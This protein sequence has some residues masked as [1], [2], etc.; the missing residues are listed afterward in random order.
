[1]TYGL[2]MYGM[3]IGGLLLLF[4]GGEWVIG[5][6]VSLARKFGISPLI[7][8]LT[9]LGFGTSA[10]ELMVSA[11]AALA[12]KPG[13]AL[14]NVIGSNIA[15]VFLVLGLSSLFCATLC[16]APRI[17][18]NTLFVV[19]ASGLFIA[20]CF[21]GELVAWHGILLLFLLALFLWYSV[22]VARAVPDEAQEAERELGDHA[23]PQGSLAALIL[24]LAGGL[25]A[26]LIG[27]DLLV[28]G[29]SDIARS[30]GV[31]ESV[32][33]L[34]LVAF[35]TS[36]PELAT[37]FT[38]VRRGHCDVAL[39]TV[40][41][42]NMFNL[43]GVMGV[44]A[45][46]ANVPVDP[47]FLKHDLWVMLAAAVCILPFALKRTQIGRGVGAVFVIAYGTYIASLYLGMA[48]LHTAG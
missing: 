15:N 34:S 36:L 23:V 17:R 40:L 35:G 37:A 20:L 25:I 47:G 46:I 29:A 38:A 30:M 44:T 26:L 48:A 22:R 4:W 24:R 39:G 11:D 10:P 7:I 21:T 27:A 16:N 14:G 19:G 42:S 3:V 32:I 41:G 43:L 8:G 13:I 9:V 18:R 2:M 31:P 12:G 1:M 33:G 6:S 5:G 28:N 45:V